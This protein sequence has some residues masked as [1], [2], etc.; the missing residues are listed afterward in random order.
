MCEF[1]RWSTPCPWSRLSRH[2]ETEHRL[3]RWKPRARHETQGP[4][5]DTACRAGRR[6]IT[7]AMAP[8]RAS[9]RRAAP[10][11]SLAGAVALTVT[12]AIRSAHAQLCTL[13][14]APPRATGWAAASVLGVAGTSQDHCTTAGA[15]NLT[16]ACARARVCVECVQLWRPH[17]PSLPSVPTEAREGVYPCRCTQ[18][19]PAVSRSAPKASS[20]PRSPS[21]ARRS[22]LPPAFCDHLH[23]AAVA[24]APT[25]VTLAADPA[26]APPL[27]L[28]RSTDSLLRATFA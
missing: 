22:G 17:V 8:G 11:G 6:A 24:A 13:P 4:R 14:P 2:R 18:P 27:S 28:P 5:K 20:L 10:Q 15:A 25:R 21:A 3:A 16:G 7:I 12:L 26:R 23:L 19:V 9:G 1:G